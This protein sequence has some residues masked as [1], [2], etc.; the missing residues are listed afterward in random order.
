MFLTAASRPRRAALDTE[1][2]GDWTNCLGLTTARDRDRIGHSNAIE[3]NLYDF[4][5]ILKTD[6]RVE[7]TIVS[8]DWLDWSTLSLTRG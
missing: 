3:N 7:V 5:F 4:H 2:G 1:I 6:G 8:Q